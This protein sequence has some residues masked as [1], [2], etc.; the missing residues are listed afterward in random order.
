MRRRDL[1]VGAGLAFSTLAGCLGS[2]RERL[3]ERPPEN[4]VRDG[5]Q[6]AI[7]QSNTVASQLGAA[8]DEVDDPANIAIDEPRLRDRLSRARTAL[9]TAESA[10]A[11][12]DFQAALTATGDYVDAVGGT[13]DAT[14]RL[15]DAGDPLQTLADHLFAQEFDAAADE[16]GTLQPILDDARSMVAA[17]ESTAQGIDA[18]AIDEYGARTDELADGIATLREITVG[19]DELAAGYEDLLDGRARLDEG[20]A[21][22]EQGNYS[23]AETAF[24]DAKSLFSDATVHFETARTETSGQFSTRIDRALC[25]SGNLENAAEHFAAA[26]AAAQE[27][28]LTTAQ[29]ESVA[30][31][32]DLEAATNC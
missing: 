23:T 1:L 31:D 21:E 17:A 26:A 16:L 29:N 28:D 20:R 5:I 25:R 11:A 18:E 2:D 15:T 12:G 22:S 27:G 32:A 4:V 3:S 8:S 14:A 19:G 13:L 6:T 24:L 9:S 10:E 30:G 7:G